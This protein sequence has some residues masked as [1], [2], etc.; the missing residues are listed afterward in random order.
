MKQLLGLALPVSAWQGA[1]ARLAVLAGRHVV[2]VSGHHAP[3]AVAEAA[4][5]A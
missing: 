2:T 4:V 5:M 3:A 1:G